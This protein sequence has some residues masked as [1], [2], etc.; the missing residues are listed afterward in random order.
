MSSQSEQNGNEPGGHVYPAAPSH[1]PISKALE[2]SYRSSAALGSDSL[3][4]ANHPGIVSSE[5]MALLVDG[6]NLFYAASY[7]GIEI[8]YLRLLSA[9]T[10][11]R[12]LLRAYFYTGVDPHNEKQR[13]FLLW[14][15][16]HGY[17]VI[18]K[19]LM[20]YTDGSRKANLHVE[21]AVD[22]LQLAE[23][24]STVTVLSGDG[25]LT[26]ALDAL[27]RR[28]VRIEVVS[29]QSM[30]SDALIDIADCYTDLADLQTQIRKQ[31]R[32]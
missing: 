23:H 29:L 19:D 4:R 9:L 20:Q 2:T 1:S 3:A 24:C 11:E 31:R 6:S 26:Y 27:S 12:Q 5:R 21:M 7:L 30:T 22:M 15:S 16:R 14:L 25:H 32:L 13:G 18:S 10:A 17:R 28:G 8:D